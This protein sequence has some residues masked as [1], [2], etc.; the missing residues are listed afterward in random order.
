MKSILHLSKTMVTAGRSFGLRKP[1]Q[2]CNNTLEDTL[3]WRWE[4]GQWF[5]Y[6]LDGYHPLVA[7]APVVHVSGYEAAAFAAWS[8]ARLPTEFEWEYAASKESNHCG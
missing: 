1:G 4:D 8:D 6:R 5:E 7:N 3:Y 2:T